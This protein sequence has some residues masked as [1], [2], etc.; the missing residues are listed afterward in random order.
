VYSLLIQSCFVEQIGYGGLLGSSN[1]QNP[2][3]YSSHSLLS[4]FS[5]SFS[6]LSQTFHNSSVLLQVVSEPLHPLLAVVFLIMAMM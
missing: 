6:N 1:C 5:Q 4:I 3:Y 2:K